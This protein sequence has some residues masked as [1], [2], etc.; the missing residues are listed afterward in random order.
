MYAGG[1]WDM[2]ID[3]RGVQI[4]SGI[5]QSYRKSLVQPPAEP[6]QPLL[7]PLPGSDP[8]VWRV[9][10][11]RNP[12]GSINVISALNWVRND[13][14][15]ENW[16]GTTRLYSN[17]AGFQSPKR[18]WSSADQTLNV[19]ADDREAGVRVERSGPRS[20]E[21]VEEPTTAVALK[22][23]DLSDN[24]SAQTTYGIDWRLPVQLDKDLPLPAEMSRYTYQFS[25]MGALQSPV[26]ASAA[27]NPQVTFSYDPW[28]IQFL[29]ALPAT[30]GTMGEAVA[31]WL[32]GTNIE[33]AMVAF[34][35]FGSS[36]VP[37]TD[38]PSVN[39]NS[40]SMF[41]TARD[42]KDRPGDVLGQLPN[43]YKPLAPDDVSFGQCRLV[44]V[45]HYRVYEHFIKQF[46]IYDYNGFAGQR[47]AKADKWV[48]GG[49]TG[50]YE[51]LNVIPN[52][53]Q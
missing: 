46:D 48:E 30:A 15:T 44:E 41:N 16:Y 3:E 40:E 36:L 52:L 32:G 18:T 25:T 20:G 39:T 53:N 22:V 45:I 31:P 43:G 7:S 38:S 21:G 37:P 8:P 35:M 1:Y 47:I 14:G 23:V 50:R 19:L 51:S 17:E 10:I 29:A 2:E 13:N 12:D 9:P 6:G 28:F 34:K 11:K 42:L 24:A 26:E 33:Q 49:F 4:S 5:E 27:I